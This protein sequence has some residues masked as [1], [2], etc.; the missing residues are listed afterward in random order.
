MGAAAVAVIQIRERHIVA[1]FKDAGVT[2]TERARTPDELN[3][4]THGAAWRLLRNHAI[5]REAGEGKF[6]LDVL[7]W[8]AAVRSRR[9]RMLIVAV[10][11]AAA[12]LWYFGPFR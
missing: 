6:Y 8:D 10:L 4:G 1:A 7:S 3:V 11:L 9:Q 12:A 2:T 5:V